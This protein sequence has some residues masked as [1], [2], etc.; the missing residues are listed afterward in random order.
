DVLDG[1]GVYSEVYITVDDDLL[2]LRK[3]SHRL[4]LTE[5][6]DN[7]G[8]AGAVNGHTLIGEKTAD[9]VRPRH[10]TAVSESLRTLPRIVLTAPVGVPE[11]SPTG[12]SLGNGEGP[13]DH[14]GTTSG[15]RLH[16]QLCQVKNSLRLMHLVNEARKAAGEDGKG[17]GRGGDLTANLGFE[18]Q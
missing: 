13:V 2:V 16:H 10:D 1:L 7:L 5:G 6:L 14:V 9:V 4:E 17:R 11:E 3:P 15:Q 12:S 18:G 8:L